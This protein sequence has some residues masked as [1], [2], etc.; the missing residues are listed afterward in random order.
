MRTRTAVRLTTAVGALAIAGP[1]AAQAESRTPTA[2]RGTNTWVSPT[3]PDT[4]Q[5]RVRACMI[6]RRWPGGL[7]TDHH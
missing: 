1:V 2:P 7:G 5:T 6:G 4:P 3:L